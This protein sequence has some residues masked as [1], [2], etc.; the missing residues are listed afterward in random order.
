MGNDL[1]LKNKIKKIEQFQIR[2]GKALEQIAQRN[3][4]CLIHMF[5]VRLGSKS[6]PSQTGRCPSLYQGVEK[7]SPHFCYKHA[8]YFEF[9]AEV[10]QTSITTPEYIFFLNRMLQRERIFV[11]FN[12]NHFPILISFN[13]RGKNIS[14]F[15]KM[16]WN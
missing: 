13:D 3:C 5:K 10:Q 16:L 4:G 6:D 2:L 1:K 9:S 8:Y 15:I 14:I 11:E 12:S 7:S